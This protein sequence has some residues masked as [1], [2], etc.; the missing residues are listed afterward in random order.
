MG[1]R[2]I[3]TARTNKDQVREEFDAGE[4]KPAVLRL[5]LLELFF[6]FFDP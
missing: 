2:D 5:K 6:I 1:T 4:L 3:T